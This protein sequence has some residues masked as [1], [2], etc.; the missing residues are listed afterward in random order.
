MIQ[1]IYFNLETI[2]YDKIC[3]LHEKIFLEKEKGKTTNKRKKVEKKDMKLLEKKYSFFIHNLISR[4][5]SSDENKDI[6]YLRAE[7]LRDIFGRDYTIMIDILKMEG[8]IKLEKEYIEG[9]QCNGYKIENLK[10]KVRFSYKPYYYPYKPF[11]DRLEK[12]IE[13][14]QKNAIKSI[15]KSLTPKVYEKYIKSLNKLKFNQKK[16]QEYIDIHFKEDS[17]SKAYHLMIKD[18][19]KEKNFQIKESKKKDNKDKRIYHILTSTPRE[20]KY[21]LN[22]KYIVDIHNSHPILFNSIIYDKYNIP[23]NKRYDISNKIIEINKI[24]NKYNY[25]IYNNKYKNGHHV[26]NSLNNKEMNF[27]LPPDVLKYIYLTST[28]QFWDKIL[29]E[30]YGKVGNYDL[31]RQDI[32]QLMFAFVFY[33]KE[34][35]NKRKFARLFE[36]QFPNVF[37]L[38]ESFKDGIKKEEDRTVLSAK[39][40]TL[41]SKLFR[42]AL[43]IL[44]KRGYEVVSL[45]DAIVV[46]DT[47]ANEKCT[48]EEVKI[49]LESVFR[50]EGLICDCSVDIYG[51]KAM[52]DFL[53]S[54][55]DLRQKGEEYILSIRD[56]EEFKELIKDYDEGKSEIIWTKDKKGVM[57]HPKDIKDLMYKECS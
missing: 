35:P 30:D 31:T 57:L 3:Q 39:L 41:E 22:I 28:G 25:N 48:Q 24:I 27:I 4:Q 42:K 51:E 38:V 5:L 43:K 6:A 44:F 8:I 13:E 34:Y 14:W 12:N 19:Y 50:N 20:L 9:E 37:R 45:H 49:V 47:K 55:R 36:K 40:R 21:F 52:E 7:W 54:E 23:K 26:D 46:L 32:K 16:A 53:A 33:S 15:E 10:E 2:D 11:I 18:W 56:K 1:K 29:E 17:Y